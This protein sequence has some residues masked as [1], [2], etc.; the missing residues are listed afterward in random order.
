MFLCVIVSLCLFV[1]ETYK[2]SPGNSIYEYDLNYRTKI[3]N[4]KTCSYIMLVKLRIFKDIFV[5]KNN[6]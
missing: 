4:T 5:Q 3:P 6:T 1:L 2:K